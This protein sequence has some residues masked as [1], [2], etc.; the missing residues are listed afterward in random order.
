MRGYPLLR[1]S[2]GAPKKSMQ[3][4][5][6]KVPQPIKKSKSNNLRLSAPRKKVSELKNIIE[7][8]NKK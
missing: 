7:L 3:T 2:M 1:R 5:S 4:I 8:C 6:I